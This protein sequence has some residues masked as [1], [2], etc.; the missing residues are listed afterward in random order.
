MKTKVFFLV[1]L[2]LTV[3]LFF[4]SFS[5]LLS[6]DILSKDNSSNLEEKIRVY[7]NQLVVKLQPKSALFEQWLK[8]NRDRLP[9]GLGFINNVIGGD[10]KTRTYI[11]DKLLQATKKR[12][13][14]S[15]FEQESKSKRNAKNS[16]QQVTPKKLS[17][18]SIE[19][20]IKSLSALVELRFNK[21]LDINSLQNIQKLLGKIEG[22]EY[23]DFVYKNYVNN[24]PNDTLI[25]TQYYLDKVKAFDAWELLDSTQV[26]IVGVVDMGVLTT[27]PDLKNQ[28]FYNKG[29]MGLDENGLD[30]S[31]NGID[32]DENGYID[33][34]FGWD[35]ASPQTS[36]DNDPNPGNMHGT[37]VA[38]IIGAEQNNV[39][40]IAGVAKYVKILAVKCGDDNVNSNSIVNGYQGILYAASMG[41]DVINCSWGG[42]GMA[43]QDLEILKAVDLLGSIVVAA[44]GNNNANTAFTPASAPGVVSV[45]STDSGDLKSVFSN[46][47]VTVD[48][49]APGSAIMSTVLNNEYGYSS[50]T[51]MA[52]PIA[53]ACI[54]MLKANNRD[55]SNEQ[56]I[57]LIKTNSDNIDSLNPGYAGLLGSGRV[58][59]LKALKK[60]TTKY[61]ELTEYKIDYP[62]IGNEENIENLIVGGDKVEVSFKVKNILEDCQD[63]KVVFNLFNSSDE[64]YAETTIG[65]MLKGEEFISNN[66]SKVTIK[67]PENYPLDTYLVV[68]VNIFDG[69]TQIGR[70]YIN[71]L[72]NQSYRTLDKNNIRATFNNRGH[73]SYNNFP[74]NTQGRGFSYKKYEDL[75]FEGAI[76]I[77]DTNR[78]VLSDNARTTGQGGQNN[79]FYSPYPFLIQKFED[80][81]EGVYYRG[82]TQFKDYNSVQGADSARA[83]VGVTEYAYQFTGANDSNYII[84]RYDI[85]NNSFEKTNDLFF[86]YYFDWDLGTG[87]LKNICAYKDG[88]GYQYST[89]KQEDGSLLYPAVAVIPLNNNFNIN[90]YAIDNA[91]TTDDNIG[92]YDGFSK[93]EKIQTMSNGILKTLTTE[94][95]ASMVIGQ[96]PLS[97]EVGET[98]SLSFAIACDENLD[99]LLQMG[100]YIKDRFKDVSLGV[101]DKR[102]SESKDDVKLQVYPNPS[103]GLLH[104]D[105]LNAGLVTED[106]MLSI[107]AV[108][109]QGSIVEEKQLNSSV[110]T[111][112]QQ[113]ALNKGVYLIILK[114]RNGQILSVEKVVIQ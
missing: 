66:E 11:D 88:I 77:C 68:A 17:L 52:S 33:D 9:E 26:P 35:F 16:L 43:S 79:N 114:N 1:T 70:S 25:P 112:S 14:Y 3:F 105:V 94:T 113:M 91:G 48:I 109:L 84:V 73:I 5:F 23:A 72:V 55:L 40:G 24:I 81:N 110:I 49:A 104:I 13:T 111:K 98:L 42:S 2:F 60:S 99:S 57:A 21:D 30:K 34:Y 67:I 39:E 12:L 36:E 85:T 4:L 31:R 71:L 86:A 96:G 32:D 62:K 90:F 64:K 8:T 97:L 59:I 61:A 47:N 18:N 95:D 102:V 65:K 87:D 108:D 15:L 50:G 45:A 10:V 27:H 103:N 100:K 28:I 93:A 41:A 83:N 82:K 78:Y 6:K 74:A 89:E 58:N 20:E 92:V 69:Q 44:A 22:V 56:I 51:S 63:V 38:G 46:Y 80:I 54:A 37:H 29:E 107:L 7:Q 75:L 76:M 19:A 53:A 106:E 101:T